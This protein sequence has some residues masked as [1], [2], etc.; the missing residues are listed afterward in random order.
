LPENASSDLVRK[1]LRVAYFLEGSVRVIGDELKVVVQLI[2]SATGFHIFSRSFETQLDNYVDVQREITNLAV[3]NMRAALPEGVGTAMAI[4]EEDTDVDAYVLFRRGK[5][6]LDKPQTVETRD[7]AIDYFRQALNIDPGFSA[8]YAGICQAYAAHY[9]VYQETNVIGLAESACSNALRANPN[10]DI[11]YTSLGRLYRVKGDDLAAGSAYRQ[12][13][14]INPKN[15][16]AMHGLASIFERNQQFDKAERMLRLAIDIQPGDWRNL[17]SL[18]GLY[19]DSGRYEEAA[20]A[21]RQVVYLD[22]NNWRD[23]GNLGSALMMLG[24]FSGA[25]DALRRSVKINEEAMYLSNMG[26]VYYYLGEYDRAVE[27]HRRARD[28]LPAANFVW[29]NLGDALRF[30]SRPEDAHRA[31]QQAIEIGKELLATDVNNVANLYIQA[32]ALASTGRKSEARSVLDKAL[33]I[34][35]ADPYAWY[36]DGLLKSDAGEKTAAIESFKKAI[37]KGF[38]VAMLAADPLLGGLHG[39]AKFEAVIGE[40]RIP[41]N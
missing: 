2:E 4:A 17:D 16:L 5:A 10:L 18:G 36:Y 35:P 21:Y 40:A 7:S 19:F 9:Q 24:D 8:A 39:D 3:A 31:Y 6:I 25:L 30:S 12:A 11:V 13:L 38:P 41:V 27:V 20:H 32:W 22:P 15:V 33:D 23:L 28:K 37:D 29:L 1:R 34:S 14:E 26:I